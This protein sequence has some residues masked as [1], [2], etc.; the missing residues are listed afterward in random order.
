[1]QTTSLGTAL[2]LYGRF[3]PVGGRH[4][5]RMTTRTGKVLDHA[6]DTTPTLWD[7]GAAWVSHHRQPEDHQ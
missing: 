2:G 7:W 5:A 3:H 4:P 6:G 1:M